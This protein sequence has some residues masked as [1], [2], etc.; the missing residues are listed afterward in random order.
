MPTPR[1]CPCFDQ[2]GLACFAPRRFRSIV[3]SRRQWKQTSQRR[4]D[5]KTARHGLL[6]VRCT[7][8]CCE[9]EACC[10]D[11]DG[12]FFLALETWCD[13]LAK[14]RLGSASSMIGG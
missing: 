14:S 12:L 2:Q 3:V 1:T 8:I 13:S 6:S 11:F 4:T 5:R 7:S 9:R 10:H